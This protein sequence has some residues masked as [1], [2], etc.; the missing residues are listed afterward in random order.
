MKTYLNFINE[1]RKYDILNMDDI[2]ELYQQFIRILKIHEK[3][4][5]NDEKI[6]NNPEFKTEIN[7]IFQKIYEEQFKE[8]KNTLKSQSIEKDIPI[9]GDDLYNIIKN[10]EKKLY[11]NNLLTIND[12]NSLN[13]ICE[14]V[15]EDPETLK[16]SNYLQNFSEKDIWVEPNDYTLQVQSAEKAIKGLDEKLE[17][18]NKS[19]K[20]IEDAYDK[21]IESDIINPE[22][23]KSKIIDILYQYIKDYPELSEYF[24]DEIDFILNINDDI[25]EEEY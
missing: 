1:K 14:I 2:L 21:I 13:D 10:Y 24:E 25:L 20:L 16:D 5:Y 18:I 4:Y 9:F 11:K 8:R 3:H 22:E 15:V 19:N 12:D 17:K 23:A 7:P 6:S